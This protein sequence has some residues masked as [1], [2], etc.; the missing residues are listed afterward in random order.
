MKQDNKI[1]IAK[2][3]FEVN[4][5]IHRVFVCDDGNAFEHESR[6]LA[7]CRENEVKFL[8]GVNR[9]DIKTDEQLAAEKKEAEVKAKAEAKALA[10][11]EAAEKEAEAKALAEKEAA[12][13]KEAESK[14]KAEA[15]AKANEVAEPKANKGGKK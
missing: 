8:G 9:S 13:K 7:H 2:G 3:V 4:P 15:E 11:K 6:A 14:A 5:K 10:E 12:E 1:E